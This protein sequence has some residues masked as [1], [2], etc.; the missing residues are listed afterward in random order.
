MLRLYELRQQE[1]IT[2]KRLAEE[3]GMSAGNLCDWEK[4]RTEPDVEKLIRLAD[5]FDVSLDYLT[6]REESERGRGNEL[7]NRLTVAFNRLPE[8]GRKRLVFFLEGLGF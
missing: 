1:G 3:L 5:Y 6:G 2:Q 7:K 8:E 4:G